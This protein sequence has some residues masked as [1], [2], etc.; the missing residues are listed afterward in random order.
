MLDSHMRQLIFQHSK[1]G[2]H[3][4]DQVRLKQTR[5]VA[6]RGARR[7]RPKG[8]KEP[9]RALFSCAALSPTEKKNTLLLGKGDMYKRT[10]KWV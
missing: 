5:G 6:I 2:M 1:T 7:V 4:P 3:S 10:A 8:P 9:L